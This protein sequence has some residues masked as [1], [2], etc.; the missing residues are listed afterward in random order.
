M[1]DLPTSTKILIISMVI[2]TL[3]LG[4]FVISNSTSVRDAVSIKDL[5]ELKVENPEEVLK[6]YKSFDNELDAN[7]YIQETIAESN[8]SLTKYESKIFKDKVLLEPINLLHYTD[9]RLFIKYNK[10]TIEDKDFEIIKNYISN[11]K[12]FPVSIIYETMEESSLAG[13]FLYYGLKKDSNDKPTDL[14]NLKIPKAFLV[15]NGKLEKEY[16]SYDDM[17]L[18]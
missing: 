8:N 15:V 18:K 5:K 16:K 11:K 6:K 3:G 10:I 7:N 1:R 13:K 14:N 9:T 2:L 17:E 4:I 12:A